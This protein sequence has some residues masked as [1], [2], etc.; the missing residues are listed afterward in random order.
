[1]LLLPGLAAAQERVDADESASVH[2]FV[3]QALDASFVAFAEGREPDDASVPTHVFYLKTREGAAVLIASAGTPPEPGEPLEVTGTLHDDPLGGSFVSE[4]SRRTLDEAHQ[5]PVGP[6]EDES[7]GADP[8]NGDPIPWGWVLSGLMLGAFPFFG[9][10]LYY[11]IRDGPVDVQAQ[12]DPGPRL[13]DRS[14]IE[15]SPSPEGHSG[16]STTRL[17]S[18]G[19]A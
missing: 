4:L 18:R 1:M 10:S 3:G 19:S 6:S 5:A 9:H 8:R 12:P 14:L 13:T 7:S 16:G 2:V 15:P 17:G 11:R